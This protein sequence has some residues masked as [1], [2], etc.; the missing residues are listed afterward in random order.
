MEQGVREPCRC[1]GK[2]IAESEKFPRQDC[3]C[4]NEEWL[5]QREGWGQWYR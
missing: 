3:A 2:S 1:L 4:L 5:D